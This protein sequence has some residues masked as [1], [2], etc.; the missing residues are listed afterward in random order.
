MF[1]Q[2]PDLIELLCE[3]E[4]VIMMTS[5]MVGTLWAMAQKALSPASWVWPSNA[6]YN[7]YY[8]L[9]TLPLL[10][11]IM[12]VI[13][14]RPYRIQNLLMEAWWCLLRCPLSFSV[15]SSWRSQ[16][17]I[18]KIAMSFI[19]SHSSLASHAGGGHSASFFS[20]CQGGNCTKSLGNFHL[21]WGLKPCSPDCISSSPPPGPEAAVPEESCIHTDGPRHGV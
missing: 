1:Q 21:P 7:F 5:D 3:M 12:E 6:D 4:A 8:Y 10:F 15:S 20:L 18:F 2:L 16:L 14:G 19:S 17:I 13:L 11:S 9:V